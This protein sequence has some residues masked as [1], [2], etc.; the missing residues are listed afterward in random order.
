MVQYVLCCE[1][2][3]RIQH[4]AQYIELIAEVLELA[5]RQD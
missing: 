1:E 3:Y 5:D 4:W 2:H